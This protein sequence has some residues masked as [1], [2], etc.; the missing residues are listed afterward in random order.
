MK[1]PDLNSGSLI[2]LILDQ[3]FCDAQFQRATRA[4]AALQRLDVV[5]LVREDHGSNEKK[6]D[7]A[8][9]RGIREPLLQRGH[10]GVLHQRR[11]R[12]K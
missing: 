6:C 2:T 12:A 9:T 3:G 8:G 4:V 1:V 5:P 7:V 10:H 11:A